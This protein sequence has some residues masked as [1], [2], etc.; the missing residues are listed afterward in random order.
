MVLATGLPF[1]VVMGWTKT[2][3]AA[4]QRAIGRHWEMTASLNGI[5]AMFGGSKK[6]DATELFEKKVRNMK[7]ATGRKTLALEEVL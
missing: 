5:Q 7:N 2:Q 4:V 6:P 3:F 1:E